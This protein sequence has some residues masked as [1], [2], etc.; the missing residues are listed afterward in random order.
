MRPFFTQTFH[1]LNDTAGEK[2]GGTKL[3]FNLNCLVAEPVFLCVIPNACEKLPNCSYFLEKP[4]QRGSVLLILGE[5]AM[6]SLL[7]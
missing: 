4:S 1:I 3:E 2:F 6:H 7:T 5:V